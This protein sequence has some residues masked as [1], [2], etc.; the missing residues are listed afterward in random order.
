MD[1]PALHTAEDAT[2][3]EL[4][5]ASGRLLLMVTAVAVVVMP[6]LQIGRAHV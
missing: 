1:G 6:L 2:A 4:R 3:G 5:R